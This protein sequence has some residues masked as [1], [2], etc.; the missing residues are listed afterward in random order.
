MRSFNAEVR[1]LLETRIRQRVQSHAEAHGARVAIEYIR[2]Y[3]VLINSEPETALALHS[4]Q[5]DYA[6]ENLVVG[7]AF[8]TRLVERSL[9]SDGAA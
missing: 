2:G 7:A 9:G 3:P 6:D 1:K 8:W 4:A 5:Y